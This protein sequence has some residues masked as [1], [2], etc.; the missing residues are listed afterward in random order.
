MNLSEPTRAYIYRVLFA[1][2]VL[3]VA[4]GRISAAEAPLW[5]EFAAAVLGLSNLLAA[6][7]TST[8]RS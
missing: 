7:N 3:A 2:S 4:Y 5:L 6:A 1:V 8:T